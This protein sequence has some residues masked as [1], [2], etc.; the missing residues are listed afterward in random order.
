MRRAASAALAAVAIA[1]ARPPAPAA[2]QQPPV[3]DGFTI[4]AI[5]VGTAGLFDDDRR[6]PSWVRRLADALSWRT[7]EHVARA[8]LVFA[9]G[10]RCDARR[11]ADTE[12]LLR[13]Q[14]YLRSAT[15]VTTPAPGGQVDVEIQTRDDWSLGADLSIVAH[16]PNALRSARLTETNLFGQGV[17]GQVRY[18]NRGRRPGAVLDLVHRHVL[19][20]NYVELNAGR[21]SVGPVAEIEAYHP[22]DS[23]FDRVGWLTGVRYRED[24]FAFLAPGLGGATLPTRYQ[25]FTVAAEGRIGRIGRQ[26]LLG[27]SMQHTR[28]RPSGGALAGEPAADSLAQAVLNGRYGD[29][30]RFAANLVLG[31]RSVRRVK[32]TRLDAVHTTEDV[33]EGAEG[34][35]TIG[36]GLAVGGLA[37]DLFLM[38]EAFAGGAPFGPALLYAR[39][40]VEGLRPSGASVWRDV[41]AAGEAFAYAPT[42]RRGVMVL[43]VH[44]SGGWRTTTPFQLALGEGDGLRGFGRGLPVGRRAVGHLEYRHYAGTLQ[45]VGDIGWAAFIDAGRGWA[46]DA[47]FAQE[48]DL[49]AAAGIGLRF[50]FP[51]G[52]KYVFRM[53][54]AAPVSGGSGLELRF[55]T[56]QQF[57]ILRQET[58]DLRRSRQPVATQ[59]PFNSFAY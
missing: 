20:R 38:A 21:T 9:E 35:V 24:P 11:L 12:R 2:A 49:R 36:R 25:I 39:A 30:E 34:R 18:D 7:R 45:G 44:A 40:R 43:G 4:R 5:R 26:L 10:D 29:R 47:P 16:R 33:R 55:G 22:F 23:E 32:R 54:V 27:L 6:V 46:G 56:R 19:G 58:S 50:A 13:A 8:D 57:G 15:V 53:D 41:I 31:A 3:C 37:G 52:S 59:P 42:S 51:P 1:G 48:Y 28:V 17:T 14:P